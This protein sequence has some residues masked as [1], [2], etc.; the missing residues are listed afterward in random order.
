M[1]VKAKPIPVSEINSD[2]HISLRPAMELS[3]L[4]A[5]VMFDVE[6][7]CY[8]RVQQ[9]RSLDQ[10]MMDALYT[11]AEFSVV[12][13]NALMSQNYKFSRYFPTPVKDE[14]VYFRLVGEAFARRISERG[15]GG[16]EKQSRLR[17]PASRESEIKMN[18]GA[19]PYGGDSKFPAEIEWA[20]IIRDA[21]VIALELAEEL[22]KRM[23]EYDE[24]VGVDRE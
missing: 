3:P 8:Y 16:E 13:V 1:T 15:E 6:T 21:K 14:T 10:R 18:W 22:E 12:G 4:D 20:G 5:A 19:H 23:T 17:D 7:H 2:D 11:V 24:H 9:G